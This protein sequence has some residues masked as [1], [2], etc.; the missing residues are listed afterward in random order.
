MTNDMSNQWED[1]LKSEY[2]NCCDMREYKEKNNIWNERITSL[3][4]KGAKIE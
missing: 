1:E 4:T 2:L 3:R